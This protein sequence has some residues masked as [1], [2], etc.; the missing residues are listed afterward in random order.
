M[1][2]FQRPM[3]VDTINISPPYLSTSFLS[4]K[5]IISNRQYI[6]DNQTG[7]G[8]LHQAQTSKGRSIFF[9]L[10]ATTPAFRSAH[11]QGRPLPVLSWVQQAQG[12]EY[13][14]SALGEL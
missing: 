5:S 3:A 8:T 2:W 7:V 6:N 4:V 11:Q 14:R 9:S 1:R 12:G 13:K 10:I